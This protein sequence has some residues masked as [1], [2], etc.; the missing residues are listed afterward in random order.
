MSLKILTKIP[1]SAFGTKYDLWSS[2][3]E[4]KISITLIK[5]LK[6]NGIKH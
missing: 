2:E 6:Q 4:K 3:F 1:V 5:I